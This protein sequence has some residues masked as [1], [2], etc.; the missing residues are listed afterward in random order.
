MKMNLIV[1][2]TVQFDVLPTS[3]KEEIVSIALNILERIN[4]DINNVEI[5][6]LLKYSGYIIRDKRAS[7]PS[8]LIKEYLA[9]D[10]Y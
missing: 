1:N 7:I 8:F 9:L 3:Q 10:N 6:K 5:L 4:I 2:D